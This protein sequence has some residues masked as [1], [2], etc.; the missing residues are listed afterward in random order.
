MLGAT[1]EAS[2]VFQR[3]QD[4]FDARGGLSLEERRQALKALRAGL[5]RRAEAFVAAVSA[6]FG[7]PY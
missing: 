3:L 5:Q 7:F 2:A 1:S 4:R 6:D